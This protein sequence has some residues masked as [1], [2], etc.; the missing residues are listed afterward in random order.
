MKF[1]RTWLWLYVV[2]AL[3]AELLVVTGALAAPPAA[4]PKVR[5][6][7]F[8][9]RYRL[10]LE[11]EA[12]ENFGLS[13]PVAR[14]AAQI[15]QESGWRPDAESAYA[16]GLAQFVPATARWLPTVCP[17]VGEPD[18]WDP[19]WSIRA[20]ACYDAWLYARVSGATECD[21]WAFT[22][23]AYNG[24]LG[25]IARDKQLAARNGADPKRW[26][27][28]VERWS[29]R[30]QWAREENRGYPQRILLL[31]EPAYVRAGWPGTTV[32]Q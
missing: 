12:A 3:V 24:G 1:L 17:T 16:Q 21:R 9:V 11:R 20:V 8:S 26:F 27:G 19:Q 14:I 23:S 13:A 32:C 18:P 15:H 22:L 4:A 28:H 31:L 7:D 5:V 10:A 2:L 30:A 6:P 29:P 25:W